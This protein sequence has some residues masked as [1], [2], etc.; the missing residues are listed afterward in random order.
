MRNFRFVSFFALAGLL[1]VGTVRAHTVEWMENPFGYA[2][3]N[4]MVLYYPRDLAGTV[5]VV[6]SSGEPCTVIVN[7]TPSTSTLINVQALTPNPANAVFVIVQ[8]LRAPSNHTETV[9]ISGEWHATGLPVGFGCDAITPNPFSVPITVSDQPPPFRLQIVNNAW[10]NL[11][12]PNRVLQFSSCLSGPW[13]AIGIGQTFNIKKMDV[14]FFNQTRQLGKFIGGII[15]DDSG[16]PQQN[17]MFGLQ[18]GGPQ[19]FSDSFGNYY[20]PQ[21]PIGLN[22]LTITNPIGASLN[23]GVTNTDITPSNSY[24]AAMI[25]AVMAAAPPISPTNV[26]NCTPWCAIGFGTVSGGTTPVYYS[27]GANNPSGGTPDCGTPQVTVTPPVGAPFTISAGSGHHHNSG[28][29]PAS[30][31]WTVTAVVCGQTKSA[32][33]TVP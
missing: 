31:T 7:M 27:G 9:T 26:C 33:V 28:P 3:A 25:K 16:T 24:T 32:S 23:V 11:S 6:P 1:S 21:M 4:P 22:W 30:G 10:V 13:S 19:V 29:S 8:V 20:L 2:P 17:L 5:S 12:G 18:Y 14:G 15:T